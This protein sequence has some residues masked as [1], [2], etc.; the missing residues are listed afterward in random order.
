MD[1][2]G[3]PKPV[4]QTDLPSA[5][6]QKPA[7][8]PEKAKKASHAGRTISKHDGQTT[9]SSIVDEA[10]ALAGPD[11]AKRQQVVSSR[12]T[13]AE[14]QKIGDELDA[15]NQA[16]RDFIKANKLLEVSNIQYDPVTGFSRETQRKSVLMSQL[17]D[18]IDQHTRLLNQIYS[19]IS[20]S[21][22]QLKMMGKAVRSAV[23]KKRRSPEDKALLEAVTSIPGIDGNKAKYWKERGFI[24]SYSVFCMERFQAVCTLYPSLQRVGDPETYIARVEEF[25]AHSLEWMQVLVEVMQCDIAEGKNV[26]LQENIKAF[27]NAAV[28]ISAMIQDSEKFYVAYDKLDQLRHLLAENGH[29]LDHW[30]ETLGDFSQKPHDSPKYLNAIVAAIVMDKP[31]VALNILEKFSQRVN[32]GDFPASDCFRVCLGLISSTTWLYDRPEPLG[33]HKNRVRGAEKIVREFGNLVRHVDENK[34]LSDEQRASL[35]QLFAVIDDLCCSEV[36]NLEALEQ[37]VLD[38]GAEL[39]REEDAQK[40]KVQSKL[41]RRERRRQKRLAEQQATKK[42][43]PSDEPINE[44]DRPSDDSEVQLHPSLKKALDAFSQN[45][46]NRV[47][48]SAFH[49]VVKDKSASAFD[50]AQAHYGYADVLSARLSPRLETLN[51]FVDATYDY[52][53]ELLADRLPPSDNEFR[54]NKVLSELKGQVEGINWAVL[55]MAQSIKSA[56]DIFYELGDEKA[57]FL[58]QLLEL[59][60]QAEDL[61]AKTEKV[62]ECCRRLPDIY[63]LRGRVLSRYL[64]ARTERQAN[65]EQVKK[66]GEK[67]K[68]I[69]DSIREIKDFSSK[70]DGSIRFIKSVLDRNKVESAVTNYQQQ[71]DNVQVTADSATA[72]AIATASTSATPLSPSETTSFEQNQPAEPIASTSVAST[73]VASPVEAVGGASGSTG[74]ETG[75][76]ESQPAPSFVFPVRRFMPEDIFSSLEKSI[77]DTGLSWQM[78]KSGLVVSDNA[79]SASGATARPEPDQPAKGRRKGKG[80]KRK[81]A[82]SK[83][84]EPKAELPAATGSLMQLRVRDYLK[85]VVTH[86]KSPDGKPLPDGFDLEGVKARI[87]AGTFLSTPDVLEDFAILAD[88]LGTPVRLIFRTANVFNCMPGLG[89]PVKVAMNEYPDTPH[90]SLEYF[91][92]EKNR[93]WFTSL[94]HLFDYVAE[95]TAGKLEQKNNKPSH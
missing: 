4:T 49:E 27:D 58:E 59:H 9:S 76:A 40:Q 83:P 45:E 71:S 94:S 11:K 17:K 21:S 2:P 81:V 80:K 44:P 82:A 7:D 13:H 52:E 35:L 5:E 65:P 78:G 54:F 73:S 42:E 1:A 51:A 29:Y 70:L 25:I 46:P 48:K 18:L 6:N 91:A 8:E 95:D 64:K 75:G 39:V 90:M 67:K 15:S 24:R 34:L 30:L 69:E 28:A 14:I 88:A 3:N 10:R 38:R 32:S 66:R 79:D 31:E 41:E 33:E 20:P 60:D 72:S 61:I 26:E 56:L 57:E 93:R 63:Q 86:G 74:V 55:E 68:L 43:T 89:K 77:E 12:K 50:K 87:E 62:T 85:S 16:I 53:Q 19:V 84:T 22:H 36:R 23:G 92:S 47:I 37:R